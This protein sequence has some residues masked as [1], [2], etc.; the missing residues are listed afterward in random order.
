MIV[1]SDTSPLN[2]LILLEAVHVLPVLFG[3]VVAPTAVLDE[4]KHP[5]APVVVKTW[6]E[7]PPEWLEIRVPAQTALISRLGPG[8][9]AAV[10]LAQEIQADVLLIDERDGTAVATR[11]GLRVATTLGVLELAAIDGLLD[12]PTAIS[13]LR[14]TTFH[15]KESLLDEMLRR[16]EQRKS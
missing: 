14:R 8:E 15:V 5:R 12:L 11:L 13:A 3:R 6:A 9:S 4:L 2:Y 1:V 10:A 7:N 16:D